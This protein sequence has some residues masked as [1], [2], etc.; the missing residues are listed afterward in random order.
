[1]GKGDSVPVIIL[2][3]K[4]KIDCRNDCEQDCGRPIRTI[5]LRGYSAH[6]VSGLSK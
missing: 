2:G 1:V 6:N 3:E 4:A 5:S